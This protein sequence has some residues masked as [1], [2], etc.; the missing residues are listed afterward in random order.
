MEKLVEIVV[1]MPGSMF[2]AL[3]IVAFLLAALGFAFGISAKHKA[4][5]LSKKATAK[6]LGTE[7]PKLKLTPPEL[8]I[9]K[10]P[11]A[12]PELQVNEIEQLS[13]DFLLAKK[14]SKPLCKYCETINSPGAVKCCACGKYLNNLNK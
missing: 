8:K 1:S 5:K 4:E 12:A 9:K 7:E 10:S 11:G 2:I 3:I 13:L 6:V 14:N